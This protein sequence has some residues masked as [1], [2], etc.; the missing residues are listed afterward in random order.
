M[1]NAGNAVELTIKTYLDLPGRA[2]GFREA[3]L[4]MRTGLGVCGPLLHTC[5]LLHLVGERE[6]DAQA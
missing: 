5:Q 1:I 3:H 4:P 6:P 2:R